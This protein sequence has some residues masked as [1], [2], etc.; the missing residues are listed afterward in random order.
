MVQTAS[1]ATDLGSEAHES[2]TF[3]ALLREVDRLGEKD[4]AR[5]LA[6]GDTLLDGRFVIERLVG[7]GGMGT[8]YEATDR[9]LDAAVALKTLRIDDPQLLV[10]FKHEFRTMAEL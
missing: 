2:T 9:D 6:P 10:R 4:E 5:V 3:A 8:V 1:I 7:R